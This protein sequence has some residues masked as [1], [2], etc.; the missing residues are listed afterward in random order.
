MQ[1]AE[2][3]RRLSSACSVCRDLPFPSI[4]DRVHDRNEWMRVPHI[5]KVSISTPP[6]SENPKR[7]DQTSPCPV[8]RS[9]IP[10]EQGQ[11]TSQMYL[12]SSSPV[13]QQ[14]HK[15]YPLASFSPSSIFSNHHN[16]MASSH[17]AN[18]G[19]QHVPLVSISYSLLDW[20]SS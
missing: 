15:R 18:L 4:V 13:A 9:Q 14:H 7:T 1:N 12:P 19:G 6:C 20:S 11:G 3:C 8:P 10:A 2:R 17:N 5:P 16:P